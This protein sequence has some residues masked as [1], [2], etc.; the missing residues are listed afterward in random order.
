M[1]DFELQR[2]SCNPNCAQPQIGRP[3]QSGAA[4][5]MRELTFGEIEMV[6]GGNWFADLASAIA[7]FVGQAVEM[8]AQV[9]EDS[10]TWFF[11][12]FTVSYNSENDSVT[13]TSK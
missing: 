2:L 10:V 7:H 5:T 9:I 1:L 3:R 4:K 11:D 13:V 6:S 8:A 12:R